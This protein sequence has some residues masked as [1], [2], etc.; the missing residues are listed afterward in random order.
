M[1][2]VCHLWFMSLVTT[3]LKAFNHIVDY[4]KF[5]KNKNAHI[6]ISSEDTQLKLLNFIGIPSSNKTIWK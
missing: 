5:D 3:K 4:P 2:G 1:L 6:L